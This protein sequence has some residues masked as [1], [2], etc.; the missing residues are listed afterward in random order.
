MGVGLSRPVV[1]EKGSW[2]EAMRNEPELLVIG[3][4][5]RLKERTRA[6]DWHRQGRE[7]S[8]MG[9]SQALER[10]KFRVRYRMPTSYSELGK[11]NAFDGCS[12]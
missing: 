6:G 4:L 5:L 12:A 7:V 2:E 9:H 3:P 11:G 8:V 1:G 10:K